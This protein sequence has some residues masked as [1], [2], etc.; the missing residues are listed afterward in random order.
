M[1]ARM[2]GVGL[3]GGAVVLCCVIGMATRAA[4]FSVLP[5]CGAVQVFGDGLKHA[6]VIA[7]EILAIS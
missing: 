5:Q 6:G 3:K 1:R 7:L 4:C 2:T